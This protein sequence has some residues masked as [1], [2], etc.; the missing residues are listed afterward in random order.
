MLLCIKLQ[1]PQRS[2]EAVE[3]ACK[4]GP[5]EHGDPNQFAAAH[6]PMQEEERMVRHVD[7]ARSLLGPGSRLGSDPRP[8]HMEDTF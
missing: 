4:Y 2:D 5:G 8:E 7:T 6:D 3:T 1:C